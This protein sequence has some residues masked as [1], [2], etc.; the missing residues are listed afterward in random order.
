MKKEYLIDGSRHTAK[1]LINVAKCAS[2]EFANAK[3]H[4]IKEA[5]KV[6]SKQYW[7]ILAK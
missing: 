2:A 1:E 6:L 4:E 5:I 3:K 7:V